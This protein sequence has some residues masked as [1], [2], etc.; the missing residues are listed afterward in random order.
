M[1]LL[2][3][4]APGRGSRRLLFRFAEVLPARDERARV[5]PDAARGGRGAE[6]GG[7]D[8]GADLSQDEARGRVRS[9]ARSPRGRPRAGKRG[10]TL[11]VEPRDSLVRGDPRLG[12]E[13]L[14]RA[15][16]DGAVHVRIPAAREYGRGAPRGGP[17]PGGGVSA[18]G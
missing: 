7:R 10:L 13:L 1:A 18:G 2:H 3:R 15:S 6:A 11:E 14:F 5:R 8:R 9:P 17:G 12:D 16:A 4:E